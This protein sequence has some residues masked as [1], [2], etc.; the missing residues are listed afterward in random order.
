[1]HCVLFN[2]LL[3]TIPRI[4]IAVASSLR[5]FQPRLFSAPEIFIPRVY[6]PCP[7]ISDTPKH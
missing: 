5:R 4:I 3:A 2:L 7:K 6:A 1:M